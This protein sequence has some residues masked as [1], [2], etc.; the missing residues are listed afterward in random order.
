[1]QENADKGFI[2]KRNDFYFGEH[3]KAKTE[4]KKQI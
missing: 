2:P 3:A 4:K 1:M